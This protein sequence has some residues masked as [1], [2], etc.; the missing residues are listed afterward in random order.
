MTMLLPFCQW[1]EATPLGV[2]IA[3]SPWA[4][5]TVESIHVFALVVVVGTI[6]IVDLR[7]LGIASLNRAVS[8]VSDDVLAITWTFFVLAAVTGGLMFSSK[9]THYLDNGPFRIKMLL[10]ALAGANMLAFHVIPWKTVAAWDVEAP[11]P[12]AAR[13]GGTLSLMFW[14]GVVA[15]GRWIAFTHGK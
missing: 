9:A 6:A 7:L 3:Q 13:V 10:L 5:P 11:T 14:I 4:F 2:F 12:P 8:A 1:L 15:C